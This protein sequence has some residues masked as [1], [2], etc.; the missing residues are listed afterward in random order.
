MKIVRA[1]GG[2]KPISVVIV[3]VRDAIGAYIVRE[4]KH[5]I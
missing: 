2:V 4:H 1:K 5:V 3:G